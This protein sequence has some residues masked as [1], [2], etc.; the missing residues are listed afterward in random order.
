MANSPQNL[1]LGPDDPIKKSEAGLLGLQH[2][3]AMDVYVPSMVLAL[4]L[5]L[6]TGAKTDL[7]Q[8]TFLAAGIGTFLQTVIFMKIPLSQGPSFVPL[9]AAATTVL[10]APNLQS[11][12]SNL[13]GACLIGALLLIILGASGIFYRVIQKLVPPIVGGT[14]ITCVGLSLIPTALQSNIFQAPGPKMENIFLAGITALTLL[15]MI[16]L[17]LHF[18]RGQRILRTGAIISALLIGTLCATFLGRFNWQSVQ[19]AP[20]LSWPHGTVL[21]YGVSFSPTAILTFLIIYLILVTETTGTWF[22]MSAVIQ[23]PIAARQWNRGLIGEGVSCLMAAFLGT[24][25]VTSYSTNAG[26]VSITGVASKRVFWAASIWFLILGFGTKIAAFLAAI[27][28]P[29]IGG[30]FT[31]ICVTIMLNGLRVIRPLPER[32]GDLYIIG[33]PLIITLALI[34]LP[35]ALLKKAPFLLQVFCGSPIAVSA[36]V[37]MVLNLIMVPKSKAKTSHPAAN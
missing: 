31:I 15:T 33:V 34:F 12:M 28:A 32:E 17:S 30:V 4:M 14:I 5:A 21:H 18:P 26:I 19:K 16:T 29:V 7:L 13:L 20:W 3:L 23:K 1:L 8:V 36:L 35:P 37:A 6:P 11:G 2:V 9:T 24:T 22:A 10:A 27:P 25:P